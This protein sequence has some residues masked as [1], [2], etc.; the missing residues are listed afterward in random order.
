[1]ASWKFREARLQCCLSVEGCAKL[2]RISE[3]TVR[4]WEAGAVRIP[5]AAFKLM[6]VMRGGKLLGSDWTGFRVHGDTLITPEGRSFH[7]SELAWWSLLCR[8]ARAYAE[9]RRPGMTSTD[10]LVAPPP[11]SGLRVKS[12]APV[13]CGANGAGVAAPQLKLRRAAPGTLAPCPPITRIGPEMLP[14]SGAS[15]GLVSFSNKG[16]ASLLDAENKDFPAQSEPAAS[17]AES[18]QTMRQRSGATA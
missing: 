10:R 4:N 3:R 14:A 2:L 6:R 9:A 8:M 16:N 18:Q 5:Y 11:R 17:T 13:A 15:L 7:F 12:C 1:M